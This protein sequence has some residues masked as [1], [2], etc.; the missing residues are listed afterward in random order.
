MYY[1]YKFSVNCFHSEYQ[2]YFTLIHSYDKNLAAFIVE[3]NNAL[4]SNVYT[5]I[6]EYEG[7]GGWDTIQMASNSFP[8]LNLFYVSSLFT[9]Y[10]YMWHVYTRYTQSAQS[11]PRAV[12]NI[13]A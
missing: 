10:A 8:P 4:S 1:K 12:N 7:G 2:Q 11:R 9:H 13:I 3:Y 5:Y 6:Q